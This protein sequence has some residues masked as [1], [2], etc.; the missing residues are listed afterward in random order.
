MTGMTQ[1]QDAETRLAWI[2]PVIVFVY[3]ASPAVRNLDDPAFLARLLVPGVVSLAAL[4]LRHTRPY[5]SAAVAV[6]CLVISPAALGGVIGALGHMARSTPRGRGL[7]AVIAWALAAGVAK[8]VGLLFI[9]AVPA[10][11]QAMTIELV[12]SVSL[13]ALA[14]AVGAGVG[15]GTES[16]LHRRE[17]ARAREAAAQHRVNEVRLAERARIAREMHDVL[18]H[19]ISLVAMMSGALAHRDH[20]DD[21]TREAVRTIHHNSRQA[22]DELRSVLADLR[23]PDG[24]PEPPQPTLDQ[25]PVLLAE[26]RE[27]GTDVTLVTDGHGTGDRRAEL[28][29]LPGPLSRQ[30]FRIIQE[31]LTNARKHAPGTPVTVRLGGRPGGDLTVTVS[32]PVTSTPVTGEPTATV[33]GRDGLGLVGV[34]ERV[35]LLGGSAEAGV[36]DGVFELTATIPWK[37]HP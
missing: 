30:V 34:Q 26:A 28:P 16:E 21:D 33:G 9:P 20:L 32:N 5:F 18:A 37:A 35:A 8:V 29:E 7:L 25:L 36:L 1:R 24:T 3:Y 27:A 4:A 23:R 14:V 11:T 31:G 2:A 10:W 12:I 15:S 6:I 19:R 22:L 13:I 17:S